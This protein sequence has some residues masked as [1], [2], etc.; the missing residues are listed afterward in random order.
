LAARHESLAERD[1]ST[2]GW[3]QLRDFDGSDLRLALGLER[4]PTRVEQ[5][6]L[7]V[8]VARLRP[9]DVEGLGETA[10]AE[11]RN[12]LPTRRAIFLVDLAAFDE[13][14]VVA[15]QL[16][17]ERLVDDAERR[18][19]QLLRADDSVSRIGDDKFGVAVL[20]PDE[21]SLDVVRGRIAALLGELPVPHGAPPVTAQIVGAFGREI[22]RMPE[23]VALDE[24]LSPHARAWVAA[25]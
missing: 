12:H 8:F 2:G 22:E 11:Q 9:P 24:K 18:L 10:P 3:L 19:C 14:R 25:T 15:G 17:A 16:V 5:H 20:V 6:L 1:L 23:L 13:I 21:Q 7:G 4:R